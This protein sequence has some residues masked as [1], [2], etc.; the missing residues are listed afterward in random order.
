MDVETR[1]VERIALAGEAPPEIVE[2]LRTAVPGV[3]VGLVPDPLAPDSLAE[4]DAA[5][6]WTLPPETLAAAANLRWL[7]TRGAGVEHLPL[8]ELAARGIV[9]TNMSGAHAANIAEHLLAMMLAFARRLPQLIRAQERREWRDTVTHREVFELGGQTLVLV[10]MGAIGSELGR[11]AAALGLRVIGV[12]RHG[13]E[14]APAWSDRVFAV[15]RMDEALAMAD[16]VALSLPLTDETR[17]LFDAGRFAALK[18]GAFVYNVGRGGVVDTAALLDAL[19]KGKLGGA[20]LD[21][22]DPEPLPADSPLWAMDN[23]IITAH[24]S[25]ATPRYWERASELLIDNVRRFRA[26]EPLRNVVDLG[27]GY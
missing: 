8:A 16:H 3:E 19:Q 14:P 2:R 20:G 7:Q 11:R 5:I 13:D 26:G 25:G 6:V 22:T 10:G 18:P 15:D 24:T 23:V 9:L 4:A 12:R 1:Q 17:G 21:V 27:V